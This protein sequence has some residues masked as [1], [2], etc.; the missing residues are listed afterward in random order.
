MNV[1]ADPRKNAALQAAMDQAGLTRLSLASAVGVDPT[2]VWR[3]LT[4]R[5][6]PSSEGVQARLVE[7]LGQSVDELFPAT[8]DLERAA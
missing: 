6:R 7:V 4:W 5:A 2:T 8:V 3:W 1:Q